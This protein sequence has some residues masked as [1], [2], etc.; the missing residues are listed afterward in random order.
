ML[1]T[2]KYQPV[3]PLITKGTAAQPLSSRH[4]ISFSLSFFSVLP[5]RVEALCVCVCFLFLSCVL[6]EV[7]PVLHWLD[8][9]CSCIRKNLMLFRHPVIIKV[10]RFLPVRYEAYHESLPGWVEP[11]TV[12]KLCFR[13]VASVLW[14]LVVI[15]KNSG[16]FSGSFTFLELNS[17]VNLS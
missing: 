16:V 1:A 11:G 14:P 9:T 6:V 7:R 5:F 3:R 13:D 2:A 12:Y 15:S 10:S 4:L 8:Y 17:C